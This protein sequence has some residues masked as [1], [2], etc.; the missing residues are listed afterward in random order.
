M[1]RSRTFDVKPL[2]FSI[3]VLCAV[4]LGL[5]WL[6]AAPLEAQA[7]RSLVGKDVY[8]ALVAGAVPT[9]ATEGLKGTVAAVG[10]RGLWL[11]SR[12]RINVTQ[13][14]RTS[15]A[16]AH[17]LFIPWTSVLYAKVTP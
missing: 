1:G 14:R 7:P 16:Y 10:E 6:T 12:K 8:I 2:T 17:T 9:D 11:A 15:D 4:L 13:G 3:A 5:A